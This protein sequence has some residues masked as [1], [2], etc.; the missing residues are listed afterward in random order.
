MVAITVIRLNLRAG[1]VQH[2]S[3]RQIRSSLSQMRKN[4]L[5]PSAKSITPIWL[6]KSRLLNC[7]G[8]HRKFK[9]LSKLL[10]A[11]WA[12]YTTSASTN[13]VG[14]W[15]KQPLCALQKRLALSLTLSRR[16]TTMGKSTHSK[17]QR[18]VELRVALIRQ[19]KIRWVLLMKS[20]SVELGRQSLTM[21][22]RNTCSRTSTTWW[23]GQSRSTH[24]TIP[25]LS[26]KKAVA[27][28]A[29]TRL[30]TTTSRSLSLLTALGTLMLHIKVTVM[31]TVATVTAKLTTEVLYDGRDKLANE[32]TH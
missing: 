19:L 12:M 27:S 20:M 13:M 29:T 1:T 18:E 32:V 9:A 23:A 5:L 22:V 26:N 30:L 24:L 14:L 31:D 28:S 4:P 11:M 21:P 10:L 16:R 7:H 17:T 2:N 3:T 8:N 6:V 15:P 25:T